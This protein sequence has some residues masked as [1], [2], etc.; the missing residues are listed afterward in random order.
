MRNAHFLDLASQLSLQ[1]LRRCGA[2]RGR[3]LHHA[4]TNVLGRMYHIILLYPF[5]NCRFILFFMCVPSGIDPGGH[6]E[7]NI[8]IVNE[9]FRA[10][11]IREAWHVSES[12]LELGPG[13][14]YHAPRMA[15]FPGL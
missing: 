14:G 8:D 13:E 7:V 5:R 10:E 2:R 9:H 11:G 6:E 15:Y 3:T 4:L 12:E 1:T